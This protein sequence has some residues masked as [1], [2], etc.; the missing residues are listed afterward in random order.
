VTASDA[1]AAP[2]VVADAIDERA[3]VFY[4]KRGFIDVPEN[5]L[6]LYRK[7]SDIRRSLSGAG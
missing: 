4:R 6:R 1:A 2:L 7:V 3:A 5:P